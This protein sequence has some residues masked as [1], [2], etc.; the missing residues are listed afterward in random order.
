M[1]V[2]AGE[3]ADYCAC[4]FKLNFEVGGGEVSLDVSQI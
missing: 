2:G 4:V 3:G 1:D